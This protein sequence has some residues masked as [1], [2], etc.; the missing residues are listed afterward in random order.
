MQYS[1]LIGSIVAGAWLVF[2]AVWLV[3]ALFAKKYAKRAGGRFIAFRLIFAVLVILAIRYYGHNASFILWHIANPAV[4]W[5]GAALVILGVALA[6][7]ARYHLGRNWGQPMSVKEGA[8]L[9]TS[10]PYAY[11]RNPIY[12]AIPVALIGSAMVYGLLF[13]FA[14]VL[15]IAYFIPSVF[16]EEKIMLRLFPDKYPE[17]KARTKRLIPWVW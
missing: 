13:L 15:Y 11:I 6:F 4:R 17:Y 7:W 2:I 9:V 10:G 12:S 3:S 1:D 8:E 14:L 16:V 5:T